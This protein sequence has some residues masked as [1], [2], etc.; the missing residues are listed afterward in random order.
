MFEKFKLTLEVEFL[1]STF[2]K[3]CC[4]DV[5]NL[6]FNYGEIL[7]SACGFEIVSYSDINDII[8][9]VKREVIEQNIMTDKIKPD[10]LCGTCTKLYKCDIEP[11][12]A[13]TFCRERIPSNFTVED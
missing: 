9:I 12:N 4:Q 13:V 8:K 10:S 11:E 1:K 6:Y 7:C 3:P 5:E 2:L